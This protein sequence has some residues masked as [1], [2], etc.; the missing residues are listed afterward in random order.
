MFWL[1]WM[2]VHFPTVELDNAIQC[3]IL[4][5]MPGFLCHSLKWAC[6][7][8]PFL[9]YTPGVEVLACSL[10]NLTMW[11]LCSSCAV[12]PLSKVAG[13]VRGK[14]WQFFWCILRYM[15]NPSSTLSW[16]RSPLLNFPAKCIIFFPSWFPFSFG[17]LYLFVSYVTC[18]TGSMNTAVYMHFHSH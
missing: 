7:F 17:R 9:Q 3:S 16:I 13:N 10:D 4:S 8:G 15:R 14:M 2:G 12:E 18:L 6:Q 5:R 1:F 11:L